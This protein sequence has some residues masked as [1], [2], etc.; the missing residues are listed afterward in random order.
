MAVDD[1]GP[2]RPLR[3]IHLEL[4]WGHG[5]WPWMTE[6]EAGTAATPFELQW[7]HGAWPWMTISTPNRIGDCRRFNGA[8]AHG[9]G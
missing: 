4:Q 8:T 9:R 2:V 6:R 7:G 3:P 1:L 5:A